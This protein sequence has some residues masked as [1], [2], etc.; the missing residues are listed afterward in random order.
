MKYLFVR[1]W[2]VPLSLA[3]LFASPASA[4][5]KKPKEPERQ[6]T[7]IASVTPDSLTITEGKVS[8]TLVIT[9]FTEI[10]VKGR[11]ATLADLQPGMLVGITLGTDPTKLSRINAGDPPPRPPSKKK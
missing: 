3:T 2:I 7:T 10:L 11:K 5:D 6:Y 1:F 4:K 8:R 9:S